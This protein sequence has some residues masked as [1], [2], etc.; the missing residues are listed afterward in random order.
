MQSSAAAQLVLNRAPRSCRL[1]VESRGGVANIGQICRSRPRPEMAEQRI[2][3]RIG[4]LPIDR[5]L[6]LV[7]ITERDGTGRA[8]VLA[9]RLDL[10]RS[11]RPVIAFGG[12]P[13]RADALNAIGTL[14]H[15][16]ARANRNFRVFLR[17]IRFEAQIGVFLTVGVAEE[18]EATHLVGT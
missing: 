5:G 17:A 3:T 1:L 2:V 9:S 8:G 4:F 6:V 10:V 11:D 16:A 13:R 14:L 18:I 7:E 12:P 15:D